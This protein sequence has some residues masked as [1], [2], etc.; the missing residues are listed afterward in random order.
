[1]RGELRAAG[2]EREVGGERVCGKG[3]E[4]VRAG[5]AGVGDVDVEGGVGAEGEEMGELREERDNVGW[6][7]KREWQR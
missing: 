7:G 4:R 3:F 2:G 6:E 1:M 5:H